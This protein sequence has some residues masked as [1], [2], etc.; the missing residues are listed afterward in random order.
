MESCEK[1]IIYRMNNGVLTKL[2]KPNE[3]IHWW[4]EG[5]SSVQTIHRA[6]IPSA[7]LKRQRSRPEQLQLLKSRSNIGYCASS[8]SFYQ[9]RGLLDS[10]DAEEMAQWQHGGG[11]SLPAKVRIEAKDRSGLE[12]LFRYCARPIYAAERL[13]WQD[14]GR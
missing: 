3:G 6:E 4:G 14:E 8:C 10:L 7:G 1:I 5:K 2:P 12:R 9:T 11:F 13:S